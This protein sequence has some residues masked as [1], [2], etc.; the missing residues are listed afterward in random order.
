MAGY[1]RGRQRNDGSAPAS[2]RTSGRSSG[3]LSRHDLGVLV[4]RTA[5]SAF[6]GAVELTKP[7]A[8]R[9]QAR[10]KI[11]FS[12][13]SMSNPWRVALVHGVE[14]AA[15]S[16]S[17]CIEQLIVAHAND[18]PDRQV[19]DIE[20]LIDQGGRRIA[21]EC[22]MSPR[23]RGDCRKSRGARDWRGVRRSGHSAERS[24]H[25]LRQRGRLFDRPS[26]RDLV[27][28]I[29]EW[30]GRHCAAR[31]RQRGDARQGTA[32]RRERR[33]RAP[34]SIAH[35]LPQMDGMARGIGTTCD[36]ERRRNAGALA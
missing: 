33:V 22:G 13:A 23:A 3:R 25:I 5:E 6:S 27:G 21:G 31:R 29:F 17:D 30:R 18:D 7:A 1:A 8:V 16:A 14:H 12:N 36:R 15:A 10:F 26:H 34:S 24:S 20:R 11:G 32:S 19:E 28:G 9:A 4:S 2:R 35:T